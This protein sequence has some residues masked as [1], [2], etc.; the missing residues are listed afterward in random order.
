MSTPP[1]LER[2]V[3]QVIGE[4]DPPAFEIV[5]EIRDDGS[6]RYPKYWELENVT[7]FRGGWEDDGHE[8]EEEEYPDSEAEIETPE[9]RKA[10]EDEQKTPKKAKSDV[11]V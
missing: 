1:P 6:R 2:Q 8:T 10:E 11:D 9:K 3:T 7:M 4:Q 5:F